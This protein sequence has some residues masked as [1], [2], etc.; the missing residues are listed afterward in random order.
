MK[1]RVAC[2]ERFTGLPHSAAPLFGAADVL[3]FRHE[4]ISEERLIWRMNTAKQIGLHL[5]A[6][7]QLA[8]HLAPL[9]EEQILQQENCLSCSSDF[10]DSG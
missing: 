3:A 1:S 4:N 10:Q 6:T 8:C 9:E 5:L 2:Y 7:G